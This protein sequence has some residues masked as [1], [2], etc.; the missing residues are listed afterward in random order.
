[1]IKKARIMASRRHKFSK[2][3]SK[4]DTREEI[5]SQIDQFLQQKGEIQQVKMGESGLQDGKYNTSHLG[6]I[7]PKKE[8]TPLNDVIVEMQQ[9]NAA[10]K[11][12]VTPTKPK[13]PKKKII[14]DD[15]GDP[16]RWVWEE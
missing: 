16:I 15:F 1:M 4:A 6:F 2:P 3:K 11:A 9:R 13:Q 7:E 5:S 12:P 8:R 10:K 14:Y